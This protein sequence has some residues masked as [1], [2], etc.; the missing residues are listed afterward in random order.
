MKIN[1]INQI[2]L[3]IN[4]ILSTVLFATVMLF[5]GCDFSA[6]GDL[7]RA[8]KAIKEA[9][10][11]NAENWAEREYRNAEKW[12]SKAEEL[13]HEKRINEARDAAKEAKD[14]AREAI[15]LSIKRAAALEREHDALDRDRF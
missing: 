15:E 2:R 9:D 14:W 5:I 13:N 10:K 7:K 1:N 6:R 4:L 3:S 11:V 12:L 8:E